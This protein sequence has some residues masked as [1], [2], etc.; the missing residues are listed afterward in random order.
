MAF[1][2]NN[3]NRPNSYLFFDDDVDP[4][5]TAYPDAIILSITIALHINT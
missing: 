4:T 1:H 5:R 3:A 2:F